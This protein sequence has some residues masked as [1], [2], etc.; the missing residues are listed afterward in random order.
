[1]L[2]IADY[3]I[4]GLLV[5][6]F[7]MGWQK[8][9]L[10]TLLGPISLIVGSIVGYIYYQKTGNLVISLLISIV[11]P[12]IMNIACGLLINAAKKS[13]ANQED[14]PILGRFL[15]GIL[16]L[17]WSGSILILTI[18]L[19]GL[20]PGKTPWLEKIQKAINTSHTYTFI[21]EKFKEKI[22]SVENIK[23][24]NTAIQDPERI[25]D[26]Q[27][28]EEFQTVFNS[29]VIKQ[30]YSDE[31][32]AKQL[33]EKDMGKLLTNPKVQSAVQ[34]IINDPELLKK[35]MS[36]QEKIITAQATNEKSPPKPKV[37]EK[38]DNNWEVVY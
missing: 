5:I 21:Y 1:M 9:L 37:I 23:N 6:F 2:P 19:I 22:P 13:Q 34:A 4:L 24:L 26:L 38:R 27:S 20:I 28:T 29:D 7:I 31:E 36:L 11:G 33:Q 12:F 15:G 18:L 10:R 25:K 8:G 35:F 14:A 30:L 32:T 3:I 17:L 16:S